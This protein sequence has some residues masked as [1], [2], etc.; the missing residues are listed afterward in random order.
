MFKML[1]YFLGFSA[2]TKAPMDLNLSPI[3]WKKLLGI[4]LVED[5]L[6]DIDLFSW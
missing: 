4:R 1:G 3:F 2:R 6:K 5:D